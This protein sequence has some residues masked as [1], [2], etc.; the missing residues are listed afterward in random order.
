[1]GTVRA[2]GLH[3]L[4]AVGCNGEGRG[5]RLVEAIQYLATE[6]PMDISTRVQDG[7]DINSLGPV[8]VN[9]MINSI[10]PVDVISTVTGATTTCPDAV[11]CPDDRFLQVTPGDT[12]AFDVQFQNDTV[13]PRLTS[14]I[15]RATIFVVG[16]G[17]ADL[18]AREVVIIVPAGSVVILE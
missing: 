12:V 6:T 4:L 10:R 14:Q 3:I 18:D 8:D 11:R 17:A 13:M 9:D 5:D 16:N 7:E 15:F 2:D 1:M